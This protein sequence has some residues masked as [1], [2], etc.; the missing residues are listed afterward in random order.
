MRKSSPQLLLQTARREDNRA[1]QTR[2]ETSV[3]HPWRDP[4]LMTDCIIQLLPAAPA[5]LSQG[6][7]AVV[8]S[9]VQYTVQIICFLHLYTSKLFYSKLMKDH[10][11]FY[12]KVFSN[13]I[14]FCCIYVNTNITLYH[15]I[16]SQY[17]LDQCKT[18]HATRHAVTSKKLI[19]T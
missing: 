1:G 9:L 11:L 7:A 12:N 4:S 13:V 6:D 3:I 15:V 10:Y 18:R 17:C 2:D 16:L 19:K 14:C 8:E 5:P